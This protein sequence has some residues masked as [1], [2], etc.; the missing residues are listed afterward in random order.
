MDDLNQV[1][2]KMLSQI[3]E[4]QKALKESQNKFKN[5]MSEIKQ[6]LVDRLNNL[7]ADIHTDIDSK[8]EQCNE[9][10]STKRTSLQSSVT[11][12]TSWKA[13]LKSLKQNTSE[14]HLF[15]S[16]K[17]IEKGTN[18]IE[19]EIRKLQKATIPI[20]TFLPSL[21][22][23]NMDKMLPKLGTI[24]IENVSVPMPE[25]IIDQEG[26]YLV[27]C[28]GKESCVS[29]QNES[30][31]RFQVKHGKISR[32]SDS[33]KEENIPVPK[34]EPNSDQG[35]QFV[36][37]DQRKLLL[38]NSFQTRKL[39]NGVEISGGCFISNDR[40]LLGHYMDKKTFCL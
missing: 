33:K 34:P 22:E 30:A 1:S 11:L 2:E 26:Q 15:Q 10:L 5:R 29:D 38:T 24:N 32:T 40:I 18:K 17:F 3:E 12:I 16:V 9:T 36:V 31:F 6:K 20:I 14:I 35:G 23:S 39:N 28:H 21:L 7:E 25:L 8:Y 27:G 37:R 19:S 4:K 13:D